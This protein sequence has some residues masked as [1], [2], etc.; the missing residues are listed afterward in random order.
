MYDDYW[1]PL[2]NEFK[3][4]N[5]KLFDEFVRHCL[6]LKT[7]QIPRLGDIHDVF[8][9]Y[10]FELQAAGQS[11]D[12]LVIDLSKHAEWFGAMALGKEY[13]PTAREALRRDR[14]TQGVGGVSISPPA[15][16]GLRRRSAVRGRLRHD[17][18]CGDLVR[19]PPCC[20]PDPDEQPEQD[21]R[22]ARQFDRPDEL[23]RE[24]LGPVADTSRGLEV[25]G[26]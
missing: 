15:V 17:S 7:G 9:R 14:P 5:E 6:T 3:G 8:K 23:C 10:A 12:G 24:H 13:T 19:V 1:F 11:R 26:G 4:N 2:E 20:L 21:L 22:F 18:R 16:R 25:P